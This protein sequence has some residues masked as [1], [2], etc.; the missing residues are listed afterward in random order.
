LPESLIDIPIVTAF[1]T[2]AVVGIAAIFM[3]IVI[4]EVVE[5][6]SPYPCPFLSD[7]LNLKGQTAVG[8]KEYNRRR[9][10]L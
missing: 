8:S 7:C 6:V 10:G 5:V 2:T 4:E 3:P 9:L 1:S